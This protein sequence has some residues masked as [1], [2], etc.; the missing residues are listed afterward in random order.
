MDISSDE[1]LHPITNYNGNSTF[2]QGTLDTF[3]N[4][5][6]DAQPKLECSDSP[7][8]MSPNPAVETANIDFEE[9]KQKVQDLRSNLLKT[10]HLI[11]TLDLEKLLDKGERFHQRRISLEQALEKEEAVLNTLVDK[12]GLISG[13]F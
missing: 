1:E 4:V 3:L 12:K 2:K 8:N 11:M 9:Q 10:R 6:T 7:K 5:T 13:N